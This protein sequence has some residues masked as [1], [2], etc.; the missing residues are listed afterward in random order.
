MKVPYSYLSTQFK[1]RDRFFKAIGKVVDR[2]DFTLGSALTTLEDKISTLCQ[3][4]HAIGVN[5]GTDA[6]FLILKALG[7][8][9]GD[10]VITSPTSFIATTGA[11]V[12]AGARP[13]YA[14]VAS[15]Y[16]LDPARIEEK[17]TEKTKAVMPVYWTGNPP[18]FDEI[19]KVT[20]KHNLHLVEDSAQAIGASYKG[21]PSGS[22]GVGGAFSFHPLKNINGWGDA[23]I[24]TTNSDELN[25]K[26]RLLRNHGLKNRDEVTVY[27]YNSRL[28]TIQAAILNELIDDIEKNTGRRRILAERYDKQLT[29]LK[30]LVVLPPK[31]E[32]VKQVYHLYI[33]QAKNRDGLQQHL[34]KNGVEAKVH[35]P[36]PLHMQPAA[37]QFGYKKGD[38]PVSEQQSDSILTL[39]L[40]Q[41]LKEE[42][43][44][45]T[46]EQ[47]KKFYQ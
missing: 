44:D 24:I 9:A 45:Y 37:A 28:D 30:D 29:D 17:I 47:I 12:Q 3:T 40:N 25:E 14:D 18:D 19:L 27:G 42:H 33:I 7:I 38:F 20:E 11:I 31:R 46:C 5:S 21:K 10:E 35:Y 13:V 1:D 41:H 8:G 43:V 6:L 34:E 16:N 23:G 22:I 36:I 39:P 15:D 4:K 32:G 26:I 2:G